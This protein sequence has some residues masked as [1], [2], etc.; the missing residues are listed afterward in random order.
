MCSSSEAGSYDRCSGIPPAGQ[1]VRRK[2][3]PCVEGHGTPSG[4]TSER[5]ASV[6]VRVRA[7]ARRDDMSVRWTLPCE[8]SSVGDARRALRNVLEEVGSSIDERNA[9][10]MVITE[11]LANAIIHADR[12]GG[13]IEVVIEC[14]DRQIHIEVT[15][16]NARAPVRREVDIDAAAGR[17]LAI[18]DSLSTAWGWDRIGGEG[19]GNRVWCDVPRPGTERDAPTHR[20]P[21]PRFGGGA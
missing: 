6:S 14:S 13:Q 5:S 20:G 10:A 15:D 17:G 18:I 1:R 9:A 3:G 4:P 21:A 7:P 16:Q 2:V 11:L 12:A 19:D 8:V